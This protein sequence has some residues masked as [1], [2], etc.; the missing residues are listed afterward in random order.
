MKGYGYLRQTVSAKELI[1]EMV[2][3]TGRVKRSFDTVTVDVA[4]HSVK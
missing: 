3:T 4:N 2:E 1:I